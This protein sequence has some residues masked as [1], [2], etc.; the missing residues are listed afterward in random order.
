MR[1]VDYRVELVILTARADQPVD[2][3]EV[4]DLHVPTRSKPA[5]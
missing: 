1:A 5:Q 3:D 2:P 4:G